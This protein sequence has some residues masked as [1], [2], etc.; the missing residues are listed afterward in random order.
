MDETTK[1]YLSR[2]TF[3]AEATSL[4]GAG[5]SLRFGKAFDL[6][7][8]PRLLNEKVIAWRAVAVSQVLAGS[9]DN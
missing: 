2:R 1:R 5:M 7:L 4:Y 9:A 6:L 8:S 3:T